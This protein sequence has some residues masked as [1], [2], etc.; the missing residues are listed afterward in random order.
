M[1][2]CVITWCY[3]N[4][5]ERHITV[6]CAWLWARAKIKPL[7]LQGSWEECLDAQRG[8]SDEILSHDTLSTTRG[9]FFVVWIACEISYISYLISYRW[10][11][12]VMMSGW[13]P[14]VMSITGYHPSHTVHTHM[15]LLHHI[16]W[17]LHMVLAITSFIDMQFINVPVILNVH[18]YPTH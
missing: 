3:H 8:T 17:H 16:K 11:C 5:F 4:T 15:K 12:G 18:M 10:K 1:L 14:E 13:L 9:K 7:F 2:P 6:P